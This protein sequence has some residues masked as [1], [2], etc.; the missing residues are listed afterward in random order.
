MPPAAYGMGGKSIKTVT[1]KKKNGIVG[2]K[3]AV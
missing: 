2:R 3:S 1:Q